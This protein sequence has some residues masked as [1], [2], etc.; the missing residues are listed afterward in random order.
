MARRIV[1]RLKLH[2]RE[3]KDLDLFSGVTSHENK[4]KIDIPPG[5]HGHRKGRTTEYG[6]QLR[7]KQKIKR[8]YG[9]LERQFRNYFKEASRRPGSTGE[10]LLKWV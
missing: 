5:Q 6:T 10:N 2:R 3:K 1:P 8:I 4:G 7:E 9:V